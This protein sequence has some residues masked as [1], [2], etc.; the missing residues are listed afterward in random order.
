MPQI[1][2]VYKCFGSGSVLD[3]YSIAV[4]IQVLNLKFKAG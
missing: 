3:P 4:W 2:K 1:V